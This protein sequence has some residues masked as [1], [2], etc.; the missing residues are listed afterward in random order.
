MVKWKYRKKQNENLKPNITHVIYS[1]N[2]YTKQHY[3]FYKETCILKD[4]Y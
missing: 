1:I 3:I 2:I 4:M